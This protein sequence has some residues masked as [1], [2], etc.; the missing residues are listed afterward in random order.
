MSRGQEHRRVGEEEESKG[1]TS[2]QPQRRQRKPHEG[3]ERKAHDGDAEDPPAHDAETGEAH[4]LSVEQRLERA[5][6]AHRHERKAAP[7]RREVERRAANAGE[8]AP[9]L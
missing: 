9:R 4:P 8:R 2:S 5:E 6:I 7:L 3:Q 1:Q